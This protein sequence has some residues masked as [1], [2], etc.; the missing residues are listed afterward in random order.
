MVKEIISGTI[1]FVVMFL[2][3]FGI[4]FGTHHGYDWHWK[5]IKELNFKEGIFKLVSVILIMSGIVL[6][7]AIAS[8]LYDWGVKELLAMGAVVGIFWILYSLSNF[9][10]TGFIKPKKEMKGY[11][12]EFGSYRTR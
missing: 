11:L 2:V 12:E 8:K 10:F 9:V 5:R 6:N 3:F 7:G 1:A 4:N